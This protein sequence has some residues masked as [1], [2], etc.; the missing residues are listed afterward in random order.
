[1]QCMVILLTYLMY[2][3]SYLHCRAKS[4]LATAWELVPKRFRIRQTI[5]YN[6]QQS[7]R[8]NEKPRPKAKYLNQK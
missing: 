2:V 4:I 1:M 5:R 8:P 7:Q 3:L 6:I